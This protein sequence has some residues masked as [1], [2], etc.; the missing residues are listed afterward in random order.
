M[1]G[2]HLNVGNYNYELLKGISKNWRLS[3][4]VQQ[5]EGSELEIVDFL[6]EKYFMERNVDL[7]YVNYQQKRA[8]QNKMESIKLCGA[9]FGGF[10]SAFL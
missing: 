10:L 6:N 8:C 1:K 7:C 5:V 3:W 9:L 4:A 2:R